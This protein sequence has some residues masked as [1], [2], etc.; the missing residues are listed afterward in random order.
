MT[1]AGETDYT[2]DLPFR[3]PINRVFDALATLKGLAGWWTPI[4]S[5]N[6]GSGGRIR[7]GFAGRDEEI[8]MRVE[9]AEH[10]SKVLWTCLTHTGHP[11]WEG[12]QILFRLERDGDA[13]GLLRFRHLGLRPLLSCYDTCESGWEYFLASLLDYAQHGTGRPFGAFQKSSGGISS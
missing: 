11:E 4:V 13:A 9:E 8:V 6:P 1:A 12:T 3:S 5:G 10:A 2:R 7:F